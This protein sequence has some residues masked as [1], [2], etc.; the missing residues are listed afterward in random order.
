MRYLSTSDEEQKEIFQSLG[1]SSMEDLLNSIPSE[2]RVQDS[3]EMQ[4]ALTEPELIHYFHEIEKKNS[5]H[6]V[7][8]LGGGVNQHLIP[9]VIS[10]L[11]SRGEFLTS[12]TPY[13]A[14][15]SQ[16]T[17]Q[18]I[19][20]YQT[21]ICQLTGMEISN[22]SMYDGSSA[23]AESAL[24]ASRISKKKRFLIAETIHPEYR[25]VMHTY[26]R[27]Q[28]FILDEV[29]F[30]SNGSLNLEN[31]EK[32]INEDVAAVIVQSPNFFGNLESLK[33][34]TEI[35]H[36]NGVLVIVNIAELLSLGILKPPGL[37]GADIVCGEAQSL[38][39]PQSFGGPHIGFLAT[40]ERFLRNLP[41]RL[42]G[43]TIDKNGK[44][45]F[46]LTLSTREQHIRREKATSNICTN[47]NLTA[48]MVTIYCSLMGK[49]GIREIAIQNLRKTQY[50]INALSNVGVKLLFNGPRFNEFV[51]RPKC[52]IEELLRRC[53][54]VGVI[55]GL[56]LQRYYPGLENS[57]LISITETKTKQQIDKLIKCLSS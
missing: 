45:G 21:F 36:S 19:F 12:Y 41:G 30:Y 23:L 6:Q 53:D 9:L 28:E 24:M 38:G 37:F 11:I 27:Y 43:Q 54:K 1:I 15:I 51:I 16:G 56:S 7:S 55:P 34:L 47:Q 50:A 18:A 13:Q 35:C 10:S 44:R 33:A 8:F 20:E 48:L 49:N 26:T 2:I 31:L 17:L 32:E 57:L 29:N 52:S 42:A 40:R 14:E 4:P 39:V 22:A 25:E 3:L 46:V 5:T